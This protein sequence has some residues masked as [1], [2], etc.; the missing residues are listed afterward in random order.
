MNQALST[1]KSSLPRA[2]AYARFSTDMQRSESIDAQLRAIR[3]YALENNYAIVGEYIDIARSGKNDDRPEFQRMI[4]DSKQNVF[5]L[6]IVHK[7]DRF[8]RNRYDS[9]RYR[10][11]L[12]KNEVQL[13]SVLENY[14]SESPEGVLMESLYEGMNEYYIRNLSREIMKGLKENAYKAKF[15]GGSPPL[16]F[17]I[18]S[19]LNF[20]INEKEAPAVRM[21]FEMVS[22]GFGYDSIIKRLNTLGFKTK[23]KGDFGKNS[24]NSILRNQKYCGIYE[25]NS[26]PARKVD[27]SRNSHARKSEDEIISIK[28]AIPAIVTKELFD[29]VQTI[30]NGR[31]RRNGSHT[32]KEVY[33]L[34]GKIF[35]GQ[36][37]SAFTGHRK[38]NN[39]KKKYV[40]YSCGANQRKKICS[41]KYIRREEI[42]KYVLD[43]LASHIFNPS[44]ISDLCNA[45]ETYQNDNNYEFILMQKSLLKKLKGVDKQIEN[46]VS[47]IASRGS[48]ALVEKL[49]VLE[50]EKASLDY[51]LQNFESN[52]H[53]TALT[54]DEMTKW[55]NIAKGLFEKGE[56][57]KTKKLINL[58][59]DRVI[60]YEDSI[61]LKLKIKPDLSIPTK[62]SDKSSLFSEDTRSCPLAGAEG[63]SRTHTVLLP[64]DFESS[65]S[66]NSIT[67]ANNARTML[68]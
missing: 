52:N 64:L 56:L 51:Q 20:I 44:I 11:E 49:N 25:F 27:G 36:C 46:I 35:C 45:Y 63:G 24:I 2:I 43:Q 68:A 19:E 34:T 30:M 60:V 10:H 32:A 66:A 3:K 13:L 9:V 29:K 15:T 40:V 41:S 6:I 5:D 48:N 50:Q 53:V 39:Q 67:P 38:F 42:E 61:E 21:I 55:F 22:S 28:D 8:A 17:S 57:A 26:T 18:D 59:V 7:L 54:Q 16:G 23:T 58:F 4:F 12:K 62:E 65:T 37:G 33:L 31:K 47:V 1:K 14:D